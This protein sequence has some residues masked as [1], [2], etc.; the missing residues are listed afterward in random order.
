MRIDIRSGIAHNTSVRYFCGA[1]MRFL[2]CA[3]IFMMTLI[4]GCA[5]HFDDEG[6]KPG[7][8]EDDAVVLPSPKEYSHQV[9][10]RNAKTP[11]TSAQTLKK[12]K[13][14]EADYY[15]L[16]TGALSSVSFMKISIANKETGLVSTDW[17]ESKATPGE[18][19]MVNVLVLKGVKPSPASYRVTVK[20]QVIV[21]GRWVDTVFDHRFEYE[22]AKKMYNRSKKI[23][24][25]IKI[26]I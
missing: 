10:D 21:D 15:Y 8:A 12:D 11:G 1:L 23:K 13:G 25:A 24:A 18:R 20:K 19:F 5:V 2:L 17:Y 9:S 22:I 26:G 16:W 4:G 3:L 6:Y 14:Q 7:K